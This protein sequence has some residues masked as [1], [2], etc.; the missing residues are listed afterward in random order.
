MPQIPTPLRN[1]QVSAII[2][3]VAT[4]LASMKPPIQPMRSV[5]GENDPGGIFS[6]TDLKV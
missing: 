4:P 3:S 2:N 1:N 5:R 6:V